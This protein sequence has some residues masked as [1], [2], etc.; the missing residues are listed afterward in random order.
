M[1]CFSF[2]I[3]VVL[4]ML[5]LWCVPCFKYVFKRL[6]L[7]CYWHSLC[8]HIGLCRISYDILA[9]PWLISCHIIL[10]T[11]ENHQMSSVCSHHATFHSASQMNRTTS[12][13]R[14]DGKLSFLFSFNIT[15]KWMFFSKIDFFFLF[16]IEI[17]LS[18][19][20]MKFY[21][22]NIPVKWPEVSSLQAFQVATPFQ[23]ELK[24]PFLTLAF[25]KTTSNLDNFA[26]HSEVVPTKSM[27]EKYEFSKNDFSTWNDQLFCL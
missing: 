4:C 1:Y 12:N 20:K 17:K 23:N 26:K 9:T 24:R 27:K 6:G 21:L 2:H 15:I 25:K 8:T 22:D 18:L 10:L 16:R 13:K 14:F 7:D 5:L 3:S 19:H 11:A